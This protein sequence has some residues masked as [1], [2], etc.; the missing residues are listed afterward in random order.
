MLI[1]TALLI[2]CAIVFLLACHRIGQDRREGR[3]HDAWHRD[4]DTYRR[5]RNR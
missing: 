5:E 2:F 3:L 4:R 1:V